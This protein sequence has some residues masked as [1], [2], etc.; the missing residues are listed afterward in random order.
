MQFNN[1]YE[2]VGK[3]AFMS[4]SKY[5]WIR[6]DEDRFDEVYANQLLAQKG[7]ELHDFAS[8]AINLG[9]KLP[10]SEKTLNRFVND[11]IGFRM[12]SEQILYYSENAFG[13]ADAISFNKDVLKIFDLKT[14]ITKASMDQLL[15]YVAFFCL[16]YAVRPKDIFIELRIYQSD[17]VEVYEPVLEDIEPIMEKVV[18]FDDRIRQMKLAML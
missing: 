18:L 11:V 17:E 4:A 1:H 6:Y 14:G 7:T 13:T 15:I 8:K 3:H 16:E 5:S 12:K 2:L 10:R 9:I